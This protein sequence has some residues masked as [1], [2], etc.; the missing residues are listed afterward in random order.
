VDQVEKIR[1]Q[2][3]ALIEIVKVRDFDALKEFLDSLRRN[4]ELPV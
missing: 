4:I 3:A 1:T 2:L